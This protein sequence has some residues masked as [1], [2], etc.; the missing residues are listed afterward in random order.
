MAELTSCGL[1][2][3]LA[4]DLARRDL[5]L[6]QLLAAVVERVAAIGGQVEHRPP[7]TPRRVAERSPA[8]RARGGA[9]RPQQRAEPAHVRLRA[10]A[11][12][13][14]R[15]RDRDRDRHRDRDRGTVRLAPS[16][17]RPAHEQEQRAAQ[18]AELSRVLR[19]PVDHPAAE[20]RA[21]L[22]FKQQL[23]RCRPAQRQPPP[24]TEAQQG[25]HGQPPPAKGRR[26]DGKEHEP[27]VGGG[28]PARRR[29]AAW[30]R[31]VAG[32]ST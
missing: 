4:R 8:L 27:R 5:D 19:P 32:S 3:D 11:R 14:A 7:R 31:R 2:R 17:S 1:A 21:E 10:R 26:V 13:R 6:A 16:S 15:A 22:P 29:V 28:T 24:Q 20:G 9:A 23:A 25:R 12:A 30:R 18:P